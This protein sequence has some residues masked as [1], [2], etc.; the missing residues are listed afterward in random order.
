MFKPNSTENTG[1]VYLNVHLY[2]SEPIKH[3]ET[4]VFC[5]FLG[6][7]T[8]ITFWMLQQNYPLSLTSFTLM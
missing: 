1:L 4:S 7:C 3:T 2:I 8:G 5:Y 6:F